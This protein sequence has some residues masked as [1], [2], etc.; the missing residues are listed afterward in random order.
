MDTQGNELHREVFTRAGQLFTPVCVQRGYVQIPNSEQD[1]GFM[2]VKS[3]L[4]GRKASLM[5][6]KCPPRCGLG[7]PSGG[8][9]RQVYP[10]SEDELGDL[11]STERKA[12]FPP[13]QGTH[14]QKLWKP[15]IGGSVWR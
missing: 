7:N 5:S 12:T 6:N 13:L 8:P 15:R 14:E 2:V 1:T 9:G 3:T 11:Y 4:F 10:R